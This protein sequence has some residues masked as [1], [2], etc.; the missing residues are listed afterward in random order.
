M[1]FKYQEDKK[2]EKYYDMLKAMG[3]LSKLSSESVSPY[4]GY[5]EVE[6]IF[7]I[8]FKATNLSRADCSADA[9]K[10]GIG[11]GIKTFLNGN[12]RTLQKVAEFNKDSGLYAGKNPKEIVLTIAKLRNERIEFTKRTYNLDDI[13]YHCV[14]REEGKIKVFEC[15]MDKINMENIKNIKVNNNT[16]TFED[17]RNEYSINLS[18]STLYKRFITE[19]LLAE[20]NVDILENPYE[21]ISNLVKDTSKLKFAKI[22]DDKEHIFLPLYSDKG[23]RHVPE[24]S[25]LNQW[26]ANGRS[27]DINEVYIPVPAIIYK[28][29]PDFFLEKDKPFNLNLPDGNVLSA[30]VC[31]ANKK[32]LMSKPNLALGK[33]ILRQVLNLKEGELLTYEKLEEL[34]IDSVVLYK[35][36]P[37]TYSIDFTQIGSYDRF[38]ENN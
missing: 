18:K 29:F 4:L 6:N 14:V 35:E 25:G 26:N 15:P 28:K 11:I 32:A 30:K 3:A 17:G 27:R 24:R 23:G 9:E 37:G 8:A 33:W 20:I 22:F 5:R 36:E 10:D 38:M 12:G 31:Q 7:C 16:I 19:N 13:I 21:I 2:K 1:F 34:G